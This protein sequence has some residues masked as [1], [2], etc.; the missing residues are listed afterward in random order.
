MSSDV[1]TI[2]LHADDL[3][4]LWDCRPD[5]DERKEVPTMSNVVNLK[6]WKKARQG[7]TQDRPRRAARPTQG[8]VSIGVVSAEVLRRIMERD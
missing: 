1:L 6:R 3:S 2:S 5:R 7:V 4:A 8:M